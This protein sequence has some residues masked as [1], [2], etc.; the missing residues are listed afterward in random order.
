MKHLKTQ[1][2]NK[3]RETEKKIVSI[4]TLASGD[5]YFA[6]YYYFKKYKIISS[7]FYLIGGCKCFYGILLFISFLYK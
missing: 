6:I 4:L 1:K 5:S 7:N 2:I 3:W